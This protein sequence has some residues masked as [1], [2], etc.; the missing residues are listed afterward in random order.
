[1]TRISFAL[2]ALGLVTSVARPQPRPGEDLTGY[3]PLS[4]AAAVKVVPSEGGP[5]RTPYLG[6]AVGR[7]ADGR[8]VVEDVQPGSPAAKA[9]LR[10]GDVIGRVGGQAVETPQAFR[11][12]L[13]THRAGDTIALG[14]VRDGA[15]TVL[16]ATLAAVSR[17]MRLG[18]AAAP[19]GLALAEEKSGKGIFVESIQKDSPAAAAGLKVGDLV[20]SLDGAELS[21]PSRLAEIVAERRAGDVLALAVTR[22]GRPMEVKVTLAAERPRPGSAANAVWTGAALRVKGAF[23]VPALQSVLVGAGVDLG[24]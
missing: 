15:P 3:R 21:R 2:L 20:L 12:W 1:M 16:T 11:E 9:G 5:G 7:G 18:A 22:G 8:A 13:Q 23:S 14:L 10:T 24:G 4:E 6:A 19:L 17:P